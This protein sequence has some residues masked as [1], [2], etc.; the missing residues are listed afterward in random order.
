MYT[1]V[2]IYILIMNKYTQDIRTYLGDGFHCHFAYQAAG[3]HRLPAEVQELM[4][5]GDATGNQT[6]P[7]TSSGDFGGFPYLSYRD[8]IHIIIQW[9]ITIKK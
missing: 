5:L 9:D 4:T 8:N 1:Y 2:Y 6:Q 7:V 3:G